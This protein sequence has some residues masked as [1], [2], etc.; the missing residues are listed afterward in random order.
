MT[1]GIFDNIS[2]QDYHRDREYISATGIKMAKKSLRL[3]DWN[4][5]RPVIQEEKLHFSFGNAFELA[6]LDKAGFESTVAIRQTDAWTH[7]AN[8]DRIQNTGKPYAKPKGS[9]I[10][11]AEESKFEAANEGKYII[12]D[13]GKQSFE[14]IE[15]MLESCKKDAVIQKL[16]AGT[17]YQLSLFWTDEETGLKMKTRPDICKRKKNVIVNL[18]TID[19]GSPENFSRDL[20]NYDYPL[21]AA[22]EITGCLK[23]GLMSDVD[24]Y[25]WLVCEKEPPYNA[26][27]YE[28][29]K[30]DISHSID[31]L[32]YLTH[33]IKSAKDENLFPGYSDRAD[34]QH[35]IL[36]ARIPAY[37]YNR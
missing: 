36:T 11:M 14:V 20:C 18:K 6:L 24:N 28:F 13:I 29:D 9:T 33:K 21:Q 5:N 25:F 23:T 7:M 32:H 12:P 16:I 4:Y 26:T 22:V 19:D 10:Y 34:N 35:G 8:M 1:D 31:E 37:Y 3:Y 17:E 2:I 15:A 30:S 27:I